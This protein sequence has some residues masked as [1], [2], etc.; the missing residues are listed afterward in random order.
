MAIGTIDQADAFDL[1]ALFQ[2]RRRAFDLQV[3]D[4]D[5]RIAVLQQVAVGVFDGALASAIAGG[6]V[7]SGTSLRP[8]M[9][10]VG[11]DVVLAI[12][13]GVLQAALRA[14]GDG[15]GHGRL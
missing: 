14:G 8:L 12:G 13:V 4:Q 7:G 3:F 6:I 10:A 9:G 15:V 2:H 1:G 11:A 5:D